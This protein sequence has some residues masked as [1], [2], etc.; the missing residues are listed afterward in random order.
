MGLGVVIEYDNQHGE[1][2]G[3]NRQNVTWDYTAF[4]RQGSVPEP[5]GI[6]PLTFEK[7]LE[8][9]GGYNRWTINS[10]SWP[11]PPGG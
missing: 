1:P 2:N 8:D 3:R 11:H 5:D 10:K 9:R 7:V 4:G 6:F